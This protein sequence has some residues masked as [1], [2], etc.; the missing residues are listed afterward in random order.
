MPG[1][2]YHVKVNATKNQT[3][4]GRLYLDGVPLANARVVGGN[5]M[6]DAEGLFVGDFTLDTDSQLDKLK[7][8]KEGQNYMCPL[9]SSNVK[10]TQGIMQIREVNCE[11][12]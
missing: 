7:V 12:E 9:N 4:T 11:T 10:M 3:V 2:V 6:T 8:S 5:A 1:Q